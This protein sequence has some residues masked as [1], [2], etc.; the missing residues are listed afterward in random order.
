MEKGLM[1][2]RNSNLSAGGWGAGRRGVWVIPEA[3]KKGPQSFLF[4]FLF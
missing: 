2:G 4:F 1:F 3:S